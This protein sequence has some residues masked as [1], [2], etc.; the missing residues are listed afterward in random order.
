MGVTPDDDG[1]AGAG[2]AVPDDDGVPGEDVD[3]LFLAGQRPPAEGA[4]LWVTT[5]EGRRAGEF[6]A[7]FLPRD[8]PRATGGDVLL[9][10]AP[11]TGARPGEP[12]ALVRVRAVVAGTL[13]QVADWDQLGLDE[14]P[15][16]VRPAVAFAMGALKELQEHGADVGAHRNPAGL[17]A[18]DSAAGTAMTGFPSLPA[19]VNAAGG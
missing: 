8:N 1:T 13:V 9:H 14:W 7:L 16:T 2:Y 4:W 19:W 10:I 17:V 15:E 12:T 18:V 3:V 11:G 6:T 5:A